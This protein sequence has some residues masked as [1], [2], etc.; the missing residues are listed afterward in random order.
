MLSQGSRARV[1]HHLT[2][3]VTGT[4]MQNLFVATLAGDALCAI[5][6]GYAELPPPL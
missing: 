2:P 4:L 6:L 1:G 5:S 3:R